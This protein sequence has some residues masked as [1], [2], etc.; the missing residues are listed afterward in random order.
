LFF[1]IIDVPL[2]CKTKHTTMNKDLEWVK[3]AI[4]SCNT[5]EQLLSA[6]VMITLYDNARQN[7]QDKD[8]LDLL[9]Q[10]TYNDVHNIIIESISNF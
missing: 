9:W 2:G 4:T 10:Q 3:K 8:E 7:P 6:K 5:R 1:K